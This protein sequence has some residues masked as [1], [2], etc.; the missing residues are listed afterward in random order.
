MTE[1]IT[2]TIWPEMSSNV[3]ID[4]FEMEMA[5]R[6]NNSNKYKEKAMECFVSCNLQKMIVFILLLVLSCTSIYQIT[7]ID[8]NEY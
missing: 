4:G 2:F 1:D 3:S 6:E 7:R 8:Y 5:H